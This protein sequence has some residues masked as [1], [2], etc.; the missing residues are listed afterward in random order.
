MFKKWLY[1]V[2][3]WISVLVN[4]FFGWNYYSGNIVSEVFDGD[5]FE[6][7]NGVRIRLLN[8]DSPEIGDCGSEEAKQRLENL[9]LGKFIILKEWDYE[10]YNR[11]QGLVYRGS[12]LVNETMIREGWGHLQYK[13]SSQNKK[14]QI[15]YQ[16]AQE[17]KKGI[18]GLGCTDAQATDEDCNIK[19]NIDQDV[20]KKTYFLPDC[21]DYY[22]VKIDTSRAEEYFCSEA[23]AQAKGFIKAVNCPEEK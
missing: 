11:R 13:K 7:E 5:T 20:H 19:G 2:V 9:V 22:R 21:P 23:E 14:L 6:L 4:A 12:E 8:V 3:L 1:R 18:F 15:A 10:P 17:N 16:Y